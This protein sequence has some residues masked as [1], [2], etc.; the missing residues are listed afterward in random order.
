MCYAYLNDV[1]NT[2]GNDESSAAFDE[3]CIRKSRWFTRGWTLQELLA[4]DFV[5]FYNRDWQ[6]IGTKRSLSRLITSITGVKYEI[7]IGSTPISDAC[8]AERMSWASRRVTSRIEDIA[9]CLLG[10]FGVNIPPLYGEGQNAFLRLQ[11]EI[12]R[13]TNDETIFAWTIDMVDTSDF[14]GGLL[15]SSPAAFRYSGNVRRSNFDENRTPY[16]LTNKGL[17]LNPILFSAG[18]DSEGYFDPGDLIFVLNC[19]R[20]ESD[21]YLAIFLKNVHSDQYM[22]A[23]PEALPVWGRGM[24]IEVGR[25]LVYV[26]Q[27]TASFQTSSEEYCSLLLRITFV[28]DAKK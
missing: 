23:K 19:T 10:I 26:Q 15:A 7:L 3:T 16:Q 5:T 22:R 25:K 17:S 14:R 12:M 4:P 6:E 13:Q 2:K 20:N 28:G 9:Y 27:P 11:Q 18:D 24:G 21:D 8:I 1:P